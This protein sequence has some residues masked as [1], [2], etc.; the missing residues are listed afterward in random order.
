MKLSYRSQNPLIQPLITT[1][2]LTICLIVIV[3]VL[4]ISKQTEDIR[5]HANVLKRSTNQVWHF[6]T[7]PLGWMTTGTATLSMKKNSLAVSV[8][9]QTAGTTLKIDTKPI[10][11]Q[12]GSKYVV[13]RMAAVSSQILPKPIGI[14]VA[15]VKPIPVNQYLPT[16]NG[17]GRGMAA[18]GIP[19]RNVVCPMIALR[20][21]DGS[22]VYP[23]GPNC[24]IPVCKTYSQFTIGV[25]YAAV[26]L[27]TANGAP[28]TTYKS[29]SPINLTVNPNEGVKTYQVILPNIS[30]IG[31]TNLTLDLSH[32]PAGTVLTI[33]SIS[34]QTEVYNQPTPAPVTI[35]PTATPTPHP[36]VN[37]TPLPTCIPRYACLDSKPPCELAI[38]LNMCPPGSPMPTPHLYLTPTPV[39]KVTLQPTP[40][41]HQILTPTP[42][43]E[44]LITNVYPNPMK[45]GD[46][47]TIAGQ[48]FLRPII[49]SIY[50]TVILTSQSNP[51]YRYVLTEMIREN[52]MYTNNGNW[53][54][55]AI[56]FTVP[57]TI[58]V[59][60]DGKFTLSWGLPEYAPNYL[61]VT[62]P[63]LIMVQPVPTP[64]L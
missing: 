24:S 45:P 21:P 61:T 10:P 58:P 56:T 15:T 27:N 63:Y 55:T 49:N 19:S 20:C 28:T 64:H 7:S 42:Y 16:R 26:R 40:T 62:W 51:A 43:P 46:R 1:I 22:S 41:V 39:I 37:V 52:G 2:V 18:I 57:P 32:V 44:P 53:D 29:I 59:V 35:Y 54:D 48:Y 30:V 12:M 4:T 11:M 33:D 34:L 47:V 8:T 25:T 3:L 31:V 36:I 9:A 50:N 17:A 13:I 6:A 23:S 14:P 60:N 38:P 5:S